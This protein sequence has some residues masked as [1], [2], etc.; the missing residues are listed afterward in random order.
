MRPPQPGLQTP[1]YWSAT[2]AHS[3]ELEGRI[4]KIE[5][6]QEAH[7]GKISYL[8]RAVQ[9]LIYAVAALASSKSGDV[10]DTLLSILK[11]KL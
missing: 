8:E 10:V 9:G 11:A 1:S 3:N 4:T 5:V 7:Q 6:T 2:P